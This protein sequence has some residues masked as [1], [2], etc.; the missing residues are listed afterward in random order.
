MAQTI[1]LLRLFLASPS[2]VSEERLLVQKIIAEVNRSVARSLGLFVDL[3]RWD[4]F[5]PG[6]GRPQQVI[7]EQANISESD[8]FV[9]V[10]WNQFG[11]ETG[12]APSGTQEEFDQAY[13][14]WHT[15]GKPHILFYFCSR[16]ATLQTE[17][18]AQQRADVLKFKKRVSTLGLIKDYSTN[19]EFEDLFRNNLTTYLFSSATA[20]NSNAR[21]TELPN[22]NI[23][24]QPAQQH[25]RSNKRMIHIPG[26]VSA[27]EKHYRLSEIGE[28]WIDETPV[29]NEE[30]WVFVQESG[31]LIQ[32]PALHNGIIPIVDVFRRAAQKQPDHPAVMV[33]W[34]DAQA[35]ATWAGKRLPTSDEWERA[36]CG[37]E[38]YVFPW[39][40]EFDPKRCNSRES[41]IGH[42]TPV[43]NYPLGRSPDGCFDMAGNTFE[44]VN[45]WSQKPRFSSDLFSEKINRGGS[46]N[47]HERYLQCWYYESDPPD[48]RMSD[49]GFRCARSMQ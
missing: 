8:L 36:A 42:T 28:F 7:L 46:F 21:S 5:L 34:F 39:G 4:D 33:T 44:W 24:P 16:P 30:F 49:V 26:D 2:D 20:A 35:Y 31:Y 6:M 32:S 45:D 25:S 27:P 1:T 23:G 10:M 48:M 18:A 47:R 13:K 29:T 3:I 43:Y 40:N 38:G 17:G 15:I 12:K 11:T 22:S 9:G 41:G 19:S 14:S 37:C